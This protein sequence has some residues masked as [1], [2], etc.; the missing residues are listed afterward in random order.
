[1]KA[2]AEDQEEPL[3]LNW[4]VLVE[5]WD[6]TYWVVWIYTIWLLWA[7]DGD[8]FRTRHED[9]WSWMVRMNEYVMPTNHLCL[10][11]HRD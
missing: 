9:L 10:Q 6:H 1:V 11:D 3:P 7:R 8:E 5:D 4:A 2:I